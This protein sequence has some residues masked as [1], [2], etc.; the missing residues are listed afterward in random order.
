MFSSQPW[1]QSPAECPGHAARCSANICWRDGWREECRG[2]SCGLKIGRRL[3]VVTRPQAHRPTLR[4][5]HSS[6]FAFHKHCGAGEKVGENFQLFKSVVSLAGVRLA[7][8]VF[9]YPQMVACV[10]KDHFLHADPLW[11]KE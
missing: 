5:V 8:S 11:L 9:P 6:V 1:P 3:C 2:G 7:W 4:Y 10:T